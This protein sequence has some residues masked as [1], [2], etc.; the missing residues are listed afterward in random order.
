M[1]NTPT[2][3]LEAEALV[4]VAEE[5]TLQLPPPLSLEAM[6]LGADGAMEEDSSI[7]S[8]PQPIMSP[9]LK[10]HLSLSALGCP[11]PEVRVYLSLPPSISVSPRS[12]ASSSEDEESDSED[13]AQK[14]TGLR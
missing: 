13:R 5:D 4:V 12:H 7:R 11:A 9:G 2:I 6:L 14:R 8:T 1:K 10:A 3:C